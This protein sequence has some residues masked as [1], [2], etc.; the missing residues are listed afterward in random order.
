MI[1][2]SHL[3]ALPLMAFLTT[4]LAA[5]PAVPIEEDQVITEQ[6]TS[7]MVGD[8]IRKTCPTISARMVVAFVKAQNLK[9]YALKQGYA[10]PEIKAF[11]KNKTQKARIK[12]LATAYLAK[13][14]A[15]PEDA[16]SYCVVGR[17]EIA[18]KTLTGQML[19]G[20]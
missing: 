3:A 9:S 2:R 13:Q 1:R 7:A 8:I 19:S 17:A 12:E 18:A 4:P 6:L 16:E 5:A 11:L 20:G 10:E 15:K 14:G